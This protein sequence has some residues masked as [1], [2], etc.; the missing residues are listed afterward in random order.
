[1]TATNALVL[2]GIVLLLVG[3]GVVG[4]LIMRRPTDPSVPAP[5]DAKSSDPLIDSPWPKTTLASI[6]AAV[7]AEAPDP[8]V[9][10]ITFHNPSKNPY[11]V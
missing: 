11:D 6:A 9:R 4:L 1:M 2:G 7:A 8:D 3:M 10:G 5:T